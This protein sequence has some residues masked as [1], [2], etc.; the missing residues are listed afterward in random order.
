MTIYERFFFFFLLLLL[1]T[2]GMM[3]VSAMQYT[4]VQT[5]KLWHSQDTGSNATA[6]ISW[7]LV[8]PLV[9]TPGE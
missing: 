7:K 8:V 2:R 5:L 4:A 3:Y 1:L 6:V 9:T